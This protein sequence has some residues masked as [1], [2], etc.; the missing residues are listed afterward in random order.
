MVEEGV[1][2]GVVAV[3]VVVDGEEEEGV[4]M[5]AA[6]QEVVEVKCLSLFCENFY[7]ITSN[8]NLLCC[9]LKHHQSTSIPTPID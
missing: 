2:G 6:I 9:L 7:S 1:D 5:M 3:M 4:V 8:F